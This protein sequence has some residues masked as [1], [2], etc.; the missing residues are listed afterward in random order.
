LSKFNKEQFNHHKWTLQD[1]D[2][3]IFV[4]SDSLDTFVRN[5]IAEMDE[6]IMNGKPYADAAA[7]LFTQFNWFIGANR[8]MKLTA[9]KHFQNYVFLAEILTY[10]FET[11]YYINVIVHFDGTMEEL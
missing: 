3:Q 1:T 5:R 4:A 11:N 2:K 9:A 7:W 8:L 10:H 6:M